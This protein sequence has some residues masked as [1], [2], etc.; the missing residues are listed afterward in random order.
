MPTICPTITVETEADYRLQM[1]KL[2][3]FAERVHIDLADG[4]FAPRKL[5]DLD[6]LWWPDNLGIDLHLMYRRPLDY[7]DM[8]AKL[9]PQLVVLHAEAEGDLASFAEQMHANGIKFGTALLQQTSVESVASLLPMLDHVLVFSGNLGYQGGSTADPDLF[10]KVRAIRQLKPGIEIGWDGG[11]ND[12]NARSI[13]RAGVDVLNVGG[14]IQIASD[15]KA[16]YSKLK[17]V[18]S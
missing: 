6:K 16:A 13:V 8:I 17:A 14:F 18:I 2:K 11:V 15:P 1:E 4:H 12:Q 9:Q 3:P 5:L 7:A 10:E